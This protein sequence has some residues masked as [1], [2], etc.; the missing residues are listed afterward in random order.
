MHSPCRTVW[1]LQPRIQDARPTYVHV[2]L[3]NCI[4]S[5][6]VSIQRTSH[7]VPSPESLPR[8]P[9]QGQEQKPWR[10]CST[11]THYSVFFRLLRWSLPA[12]KSLF[13]GS[14][15][16]WCGNCG[17]W[18]AIL[19]LPPHPCTQNQASAS[20]PLLLELPPSALLPVE[21]LPPFSWATPLSWCLK[22]N[23]V[24]RRVET[25]YTIFPG[26]LPNRK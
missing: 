17:L 19:P 3:C 18:T 10:H 2:Q 6:A 7:G 11:L 26:I 21:A 13:L 14:S 4:P 5:P 16:C 23:W 15:W 20:F 9:C 8:P 1:E 12:R 25:F 24:L 22:H